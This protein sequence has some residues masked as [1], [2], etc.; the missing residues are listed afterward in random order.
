MLK[1]K[2]VFICIFLCAAV[3]YSSR[4]RTRRLAAEGDA[5]PTI[6]NATALE[7]TLTIQY[8]PSNSSSW[9][10]ALGVFV[11]AYYNGIADTS[12][13]I[14]YE[15]YYIDDSNELKSTDTGVNGNTFNS[16]YAKYDTP[17]IEIDTPFKAQRTRYL[18]IVAVTQNSTNPE[19]LVRS[20]ELQLMYN[21][22]GG[23]RKFSYGF[24]VPG[25]ESGG[26]FIRFALEVEGK[27][28]AQAAGSQEFAD[29][30]TS[31]GVGTYESQV[32]ALNLAEL[33]GVTGFEGG[34]AGAHCR[35]EYVL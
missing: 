19:A 31:L 23:A 17:Y 32:Q 22:E 5:I 28:R 34:F 6:V 30:F 20:E 14:Y 7:P 15:D 27:A 16:P 25:I 4:P 29:F 12:A 24:L 3:V 35:Y 1:L 11:R 18:K 13:K 26:H 10:A 21:V 33:V 8:E 2:R 9:P